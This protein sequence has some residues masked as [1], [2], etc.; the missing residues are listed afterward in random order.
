MSSTTARR[1]SAALALTAL[2]A[3][4]AGPAAATGP[5]RRPTATDSGFF[6]GIF[7]ATWR[8]VANLL[9]TAPAAPAVRHAAGHRGL[10]SLHADLGG[11]IDPDGQRALSQT[12]ATRVRP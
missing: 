5:G 11:F 10:T 12:P 3:L 7:E 1:I 2:L 9:G 8:G 4:S 6:D